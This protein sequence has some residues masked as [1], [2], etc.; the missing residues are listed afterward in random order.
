MHLCEWSLAHRIGFIGEAVVGFL[1]DAFANG[2]ESGDA[3][4]VEL[5]AALAL[6]F[7]V[8]DFGWHAFAVRAVG[9]HGVIGVGHGDQTSETWYFF[10]GQP[11]GISLAVP[12]LV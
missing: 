2:F 8:G 3:L 4:G 11:I 5:L 1:D 6:H 12:T 10:A 7:Q 9:G